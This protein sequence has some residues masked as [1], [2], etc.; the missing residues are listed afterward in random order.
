MNAFFVTA[1]A[2]AVLTCSL[3]GLATSGFA[4]ERQGPL[5]ELLKERFLKKQQDL[6]APVT[7][8]DT[9][10]RISGP[11]D[12]SFSF[13]YGGLSRMYR[14]HVPPSYRAANPTPLLVSFHG[15][16]ASME[17]QATDKNYGQISKSD[18]EGFVVVFPNGY[19]KLRSGKFATWNAGT[20]C[21]G[22]R[23]GKIDDVGF[24]RQVIENVS[25][26]L[27]IDRNKIFATGM[28]NGGMFTYR[29]ACEM[30]D[31]FKAIASVA[32]PDGTTNCTPK[33]PV[34]VLHIHARD[35][36]HAQFE[37]GSGKK[38]MPGSV[39]TQFTSVPQTI[40]NWVKRNECNAAPKRVLDKPG[41]YCDVYAQCNGN[42]EVEL[43]VTATGGHS[44]PGA[45]KSRGDEPPSTAISANDVMWEFFKSR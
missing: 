26:Q 1:R 37:G 6:P 33:K 19:S 32:G 35:D 2:A 11:G 17:Y 5:R 28:S 10:A 31:V 30:S 12:Y 13:E 4:Q 18:R 23:D 22:A 40:S 41:A 15:G 9:K 16:G 42:V 44:W 3:L 39:V 24:V 27:D 20:C 29:L 7:D 25:A 14:I 8:S 36:D 34:S 45:E 38:S 43:C 21:G